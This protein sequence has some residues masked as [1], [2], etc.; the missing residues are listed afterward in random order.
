MLRSGIPLGKIFGI[1]IKI[2]WSWFF[3]FGL[4][5]WQLVAVYFHQDE[6]EDWS[7][8]QRMV[9]GV[10]ASLLFFG[11][12]LAH[13]LAHSLVAR[14][15]GIS[16]NAIT[17]FILGGVSQI[18][19][20]PRRPGV[21]FRMAIAG[22]L[23]SVAIGVISIVS[24]WLTFNLF[25]PVGAILFLLGWVN[26]A[27]AVFNL[28]PGFPL[29]GGRVLR[30]I[31]WWRTKNL[32]TATR[33]ASYIGRGVGFALIFVGVMMALLLQDLS[34]LWYALIGWFLE[35]AAAEAYR[36]LA[37]RDVLEGHKVRELMTTDCPTVLARLTIEQL[38]HFYI[39]DTGRRCFPVAE[40][41]FVLGMV[42][43]HDIKAV[44][45][46]LWTSKTVGETMI[47]L[48]KLKWV[49]PDDDLSLAMRLISA[50]DINQVPV[51]DKGSIVGMVTR[52]RLLN[53]IDTRAELGV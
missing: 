31:I 40:D 47:P 26:L 41:G 12:V 35:N 20:E 29:D 21:E 22:P 25:E 34:G 42:T 10:I 24:W 36:Q 50:E 11:S 6:Y 7:L 33:T 14:R 49:R 8:G 46:D 43:M 5:T 48:E 16:I 30:S 9:V 39:L 15:E 18:S 23:C 37:L 53:F 3:I 52:D 1:S 45:R 51:V 28:I 38:V 19:E 2:H 17:L 32:K 13:E 44:P 4:M 27:L